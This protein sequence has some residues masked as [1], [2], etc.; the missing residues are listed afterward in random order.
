MCNVHGVTTGDVV[1][2]TVHLHSGDVPHRQTIRSGRHE[3]VADEPAALGGGDQG[4]AP[5]G[6]LLSALAA[7]TSITLRMYADRKGWQLGPVKVDLAMLRDNDEERIERTIVLAATV[8]PD[9]RARLAEI[10]EKTPVT[11]TLR[12][13]TRIVTTFR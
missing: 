13:G 7:C 5:Y 9:Q 1:L 3:L 8:P 4:P 2:A 12:R 6:L 10:A 11:K